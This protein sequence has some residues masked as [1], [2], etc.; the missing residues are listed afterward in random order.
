[1]HVGNYT[2]FLRTG[3]PE[4]FGFQIAFSGQAWRGL[5]GEGIGI[6]EFWGK[7]KIRKREV[8]MWMHQL[9]PNDILLGAYICR[10]CVGSGTDIGGGR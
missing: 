8:A 5:A 10:N 1:M 7:Q 3:G 9:R 2:A 6:E 4:N